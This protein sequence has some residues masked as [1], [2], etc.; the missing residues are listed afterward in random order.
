M[1][2]SYDVRKATKLLVLVCAGCVGLCRGR[3]EPPRGS[4]VTGDAHL[5]N[6]HI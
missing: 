5:E 1:M 3:G 6:P 4:Q 2:D